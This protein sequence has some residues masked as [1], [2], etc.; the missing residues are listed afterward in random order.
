MIIG[1]CVEGVECVGITKTWASIYFFGTWLSVMFLLLLFWIFWK[2]PALEFITA[3]ISGKS[4]AL[5]TN[6]SNQGRIRTAKPNAEGILDISKTGPALI[7]ENSHIIDRI[8]G[9]PM[10]LVHGEFASTVPTWWVSVMNFLKRR[11]IKSGKPLHNSSD[12]GKEI[13]IK[14]NKELGMWEKVNEKIPNEDIPIKPWLTLNLS[15]LA[16][17]FPYN[18]TPALVESNKE[19]A[20][21]RQMKFWKTDTG[22]IMIYAMVL[23]IVVIAGYL[24]L[25]LYPG[26]GG[27]KDIHVVVDSAGNILQANQS[28]IG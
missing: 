7:A 18:I 22:R 11:G 17:M 5:V 2:T 12:Y 24:A 23:I 20:L 13:G 16:N 14:F 25:K 27:A 19:Y 28:L 6:R 26:L 4:L 3:I 9:R 15:Q 21:A 1:A 8:S 10:Y